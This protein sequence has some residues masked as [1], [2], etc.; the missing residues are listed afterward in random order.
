MSVRLVRAVIRAN[1]Q[2][3]Q[4]V[5]RRLRLPDEKT[6]WADFERHAGVLLRGLPDG[7]VVLDLGG[8]RRFVYRGSVDPPGRL[9]VIAVD[10]SPTELAL[11]TDVAETLVADVA[12]DLPLPDESADLILSRALLEHVDGVPAAIGHMARVLKPGG[13]TLHMVPCRYSLFGMA[14][15]LL[16]FGPL[17]RLTHAVMPHTRGLVEFPV[18]YDHCWPQTLEQEFRRAGF[19]EVRCEVTWACQGYFEAVFPLFLLHAAWEQT[20]RR[21]RAR[22]LAAYAVVR[23]VR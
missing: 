18:V 14:A 17:L 23:A 21:L 2:L 19:R 8:G 6:L 7:A 4:T 11:N 20:A 22:R 15:R 1:I 13:V 5:Q 12:T 9:R 10:I 3:S 16:P